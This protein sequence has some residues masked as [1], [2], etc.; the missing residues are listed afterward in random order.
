MH[1]DYASTN[2]REVE[3]IE[4]AILPEST[5]KG[6][7][8]Q[9][10]SLKKDKKAVHLRLDFESTDIISLRASIN[11]NLRLVNSAI[12]TLNVIDSNGMPVPDR[13]KTE[14]L[15]SQS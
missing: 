14:K 1:F 5:N 11:N 6:K 8:A 15:G 13:G 4:R 9:K 7:C 3:S 2:E 12:R 10:S